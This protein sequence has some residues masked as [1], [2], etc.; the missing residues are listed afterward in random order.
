[1][2]IILCMHMMVLLFPY[3]RT[4]EF[5]MRIIC[6]WVLRSHFAS[7][8][9]KH[10]NCGQIYVNIGGVHCLKI[11]ST[12]VATKFIVSISNVVSSILSQTTLYTKFAKYRKNISCLSFF[13]DWN[14]TYLPKLAYPLQTEIKSKIRYKKNS[15]NCVRDTEHKIELFLQLMNLKLISNK[16]F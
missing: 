4:A 7:P 5:Q 10:W 2:C 6:E 1:M 16:V 14:S 3:V 11:Y 9:T 15:K 13:I 8:S 12:H